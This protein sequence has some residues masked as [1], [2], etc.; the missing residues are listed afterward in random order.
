MLWQVPG[1]RPSTPGRGHDA[2]VSTSVRTGRA[3]R[4]FRAGLA[5]ALGAVL[6][7]CLLVLLVLDPMT[8]VSPDLAALYGDPL[9]GGAAVAVVAVVLGS[10]AAGAWWTAAGTDAATG[11]D[12]GASARARDL[13]LAASALCAP[14]AV[15]TAA[16]V[17]GFPVGLGF[18]TR[19]EDLGVAPPAGSLSTALAVTSGVGV[20]AVAVGALLALVA[21]ALRARARWSEG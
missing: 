15:A 13:S 5:L 14:G 20:A 16:G 18:Y 4:R 8:T 10:V 17:L 2:G 21:V 9:R 3:S 1:E 19:A 6:L 12:R 11:R 7:W